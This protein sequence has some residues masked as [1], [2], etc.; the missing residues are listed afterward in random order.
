MSKIFTQAELKSI[1][2]REQGNKADKNGLFSRRVRPKIEEILSLDLK[3]LR[4]L[5]KRD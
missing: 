5:I 3:R 2:E 1:E 4:R